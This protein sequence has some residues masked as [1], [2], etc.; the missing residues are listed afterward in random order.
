MNVVTGCD[1][2][3]KVAR[4]AIAGL[5]AGML[6]VTNC[7]LVERV[8]VADGIKNNNEEKN[9]M[10]FT[11]PELPFEKNA[12]EP[13][14]SAETLEFHHG[15]HHA[16]YVNNLNN[17]VADKPEA[18]MTLEQVIMVAEGPMFNNAAQVWNHSFYWNC[19]KKDGGGVPTGELAAAIDRDFG[20]FDA[21]VKEFTAAAVG[22]FGS[23][24]AWL[25]IE[26]GK[27]K[28]TKTG[29]ADLPMKH[30]QV[31]LMTVDVWE[32]AYYIDYRNAR[33][34]YVETFLQKL[35]N[36]DFVAANYKAAK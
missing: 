23:G 8:A 18:A 33:P 26:G 12:L 9:A 11:L 13:Y 4:V 29:N 14:I 32:H 28:V 25:V 27:L 30:G 34:K 24:W 6:C 16:A 31:A 3:G 15:K 36:W 5:V 17:M 19:M 21:F 22:Q 35:V 10:S 20:S 2:S 7:A 1:A